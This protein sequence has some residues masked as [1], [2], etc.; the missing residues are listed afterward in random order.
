VS[1]TP[2][3]NRPKPCGTDDDGG[4]YDMRH[5]SGY[6]RR[7]QLYV[8]R[9]YN[10]VC[11]SP[12]CGGPTAG[13]CCAASAR[14][15][16]PTSLRTNLQEGDRCHVSLSFWRRGPGFWSHWVQR[17]LLFQYFMHFYVDGRCE[18]ATRGVC[19]HSRLSGAPGH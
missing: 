7:H 3:R 13:R 8:R 17:N 15:R 12:R 2:R 19:A 5:V 1:S 6:G 11:S 18:R 16:S 4:Q 9:R 10:V 14:R